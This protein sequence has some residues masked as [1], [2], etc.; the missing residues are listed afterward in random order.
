MSTKAQAN[1]IYRAYK[2]GELTLPK[3]FANKMYKTAGMSDYA[4]RHCREFDGAYRTAIATEIAAKFIWDGRN[5]LAQAVV[6]GREVEEVTVTE[7][8]REFEV[9]QDVLDNPEDYGMDEME[10]W[11][12]EV[13][14][15]YTEECNHIEYVIH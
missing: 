9:T 5:D 10:S 1:T 7:T 4:L 2:R 14:D 3:D 8:I 11:I 15:I 13:G 12:Y 6:N